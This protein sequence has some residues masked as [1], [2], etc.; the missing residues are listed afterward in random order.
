MIKRIK[1]IQ[2]I[3]SF[4]NYRPDTPTQA[5]LEFAKSSII[6]ANNG[7][8]KSTIAN[9]LK[10]LSENDSSKIIQRKSLKDGKPV[11]IDQ[12]VVIVRAGGESIYQSNS[13][14][15]TKTHAPKIYV[16]DQQFISDNL[17]VHEVEATHKQK[18]ISL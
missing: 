8:G 16:F 15:H 11:E 12:E 10:S 2:G 3:G 6:Y 17:F 9:I 7:Y 5:A 13:W 4:V 14:I 18:S 1:L